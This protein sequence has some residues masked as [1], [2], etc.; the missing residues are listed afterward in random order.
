[1]RVEIVRLDVYGYDVTCVDGTFELSGGRVVESLP[2]TIVRVTLDDD[3]VGFGETCPLGAAYLPAHGEGARAALRELAPAALGLDPRA[4]AIVN[5]RLDDRLLGHA[6]AKS[7]IDVACWDAAAKASRVPVC[8]LLGGRRLESYPLYAAIPL[9]PP[10]EMAAEV[11]RLLDEGVHQFQLKLGTAPRDDAGRVHSVLEAIGPD[12]VLVADAN[13]GWRA[14]R[15]GRRPPARA[16]GARLPR[17]AVPDA[18]G[19]PLRPGPDDAA[20]GARR[21]DY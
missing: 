8:T 4:A 9:G 1:V 3:T 10:D 19:V 21:G 17:A 16:D 5:D 18:R 6:Y 20:D 2:S 11:E 15:R 14:G 7:A 13:G 12:D